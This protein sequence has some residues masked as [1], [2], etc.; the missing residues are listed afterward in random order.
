MKRAMVTMV[1]CL[2]M[3]FLS[4]CS[5]K[6]SETDQNQASD[7][8]KTPTSSA[9]EATVTKIPVVTTAP[10]IT[11]EMTKEEE[12]ELFNQI[13]ASTPI[14]AKVPV[15][16][17]FTDVSV[18]DPSIVDVDG[19]YYIF[20]SH[21]AVAKTTDLMNW[22]MV[23]SGVKKDNKVIPDA[24]SEMSEAFTWAQTSTFWA[25]DVIQLE[26]GRFYYYYCNCQGSKP[27][28]ALGVAVSD[29]IEG[30]Y[31]D[32]G[33]ILK[34]GQN[35]DTLDENGDV[36][37]ATIEPNVVDPCVFYDKEGKLWM[38]YGSYSGG[39][40]IL[41][42]DK[43]TGMPLEKGYGKKLLGENHL[44]IEG[45][46]VQYSKE[47][48]YYYMFLS[49]GGLTADGAYNIR[50][51]RSK[52]PDG[53]YYDAQGND[54]IDC[55]GPAGSF[56]D[57]AAADDFGTKLMGNYHWNTIDGEEARH[58]NAPGYLSPGHNSTLYDEKNGKYFL[59]FHTRFEGNGENHEVRV[60]QMFLNEDGWFVVAPY[61][62][63]GET[64]GTYTE[65]EIPGAYKVINHQLDIS[66]EVK[67]SVN[68][69]LRE[70]HSVIGDWHGTWEL[71]GDNTCIL[72]IDGV[73]YKGIFLKQWDEVNL[74]N[75]M[76][77]TVQSLEGKSIWGSGYK[78]L[79][80]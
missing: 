62:Y 59:V 30:P 55:K 52:N 6:S 9:E 42:L 73:E 66:A 41:E 10:A 65:A 27:L 37:D 75:V 67:E 60:H 76:T 1:V 79:D 28:A 24:M 58:G 51:A 56:F 39:I 32:L 17:N 50:V 69:V 20:G 31:K 35:P 22:T 21:L 44:R 2:G 77:F 70:D 25:P 43:K 49:F 38:M 5:N 63:V 74:K 13:I 19:T 71:K 14:K 68:V 34:S 46:F 15:T 80:E 11:E 33:V 26:D 72:T 29:N 7:V 8:T 40:Y 54:M 78:A 3:L 45:A 16:Y 18:H 23:D 64:I 36:Y 4:S 12:E 61:R 57:D 53:P 47:T 48:D